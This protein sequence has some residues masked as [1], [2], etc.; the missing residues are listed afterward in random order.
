MLSISTNFF[1][2]NKRVWVDK[3]KIRFNVLILHNA[4]QYKEKEMASST[5]KET[6]GDL[7]NNLMKLVREIKRMKLTVDFNLQG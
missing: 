4:Q 2:P 1:S 3:I 7:R 5:S 6:I